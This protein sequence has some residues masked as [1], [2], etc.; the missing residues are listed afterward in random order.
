[1]NTQRSDLI[2][3]LG[4]VIEGVDNDTVLMSL[5]ALMT[6][7]IVNNSDGEVAAHDTATRI[8]DFL[9]SSIHDAFEV[10]AAKGY[11]P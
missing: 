11:R 10:L 1:M 8:A 7:E 6:K 3:A 5:A 4:A 9:V 2:R